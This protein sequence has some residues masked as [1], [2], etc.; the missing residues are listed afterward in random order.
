MPTPAV[1]LLFGNVFAILEQNKKGKGKDMH[2]TKDGR[3]ILYELVTDDKYPFLCEYEGATLI[4]HIPSKTT[5][6]TLERLL[7]RQFDDFWGNLYDPEYRK[8][9]GKP[10]VH[11]KGRPYFPKIKKA[12]E[13]GMEI[14]GDTLILYCKTDTVSQ[15]KAIFRR[16]LKR[17]VEEAIVH[18]YYQAEC[19]FPEVKIPKI[20][21][22]YPGPRAWACHTGDAIYLSAKLGRYGEEHI[23]LVLYHELCHCFIRDHSDAFYAI[24][25][26][27]YPNCRALEKAF[28]KLAYPDV[29]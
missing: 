9:H 1:G 15:H 17:A 3:T 2:F 13:D 11:Y 5:Q 27:K 23:K 7:Y 12:K 8:F 6:E 22:K 28:D 20:M 4:L 16:Y 14:K 26:K 18:L 21:V 29:F 19:D 24:F 25:E 10:T